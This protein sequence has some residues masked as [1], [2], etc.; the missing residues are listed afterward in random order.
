[1]YQ[2]RVGLMIRSLWTAILAVSLGMMALATAKL[3]AAA[4]MAG[5]TSSNKFV[6]YYGNDF[7]T[8]NLNALAKFDVVVLDPNVGNCLPSSIAYLQSNGVRYVLGYI[9]IGEEPASV[10]AL[11][12]NGDG[13][14]YYSGGAYHYE[15]N[16]I[17]S[18]YVD[19]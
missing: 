7:T 10:A 16:G 15:S 1:M 12:G 4:P 13:P 8:N 6:I 3:Q 2:Y 5:I 9:S 14:V 11:P 19:Q 18:F 17:A